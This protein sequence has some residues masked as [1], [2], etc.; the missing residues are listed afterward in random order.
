MSVEDL[1]SEELRSVVGQI[2]TPAP[3]DPRDLIA[4][5]HGLRRRRR[6]VGAVALAATAA[7]VGGI[8]AIGLHPSPSSPSPSR[9]PTELPTGAPPSIGY[10][11]G[12]TLYVGGVPQTGAFSSAQTVGGTTVA[13]PTSGPGRR[14]TVV[15][16]DGRIVDRIRGVD[17]SVLISQDGTKIAYVDDTGT[18]MLLVVHDVGAERDLG[19]LPVSRAL[20]APLNHTP[21][22]GQELWSLADDGTVTYGGQQTSHTWRPG[23]AP[24]DHRPALRPTAPAGLP[25]TAVDAVFGPARTW[26]AWITDRH[27][28]VSPDGG[29]AADGVTVQRPGRP[30]SR[31]VITLPVGNHA[32]AITWETTTDI[33]VWVG[34]DL[35]GHGL[36]YL[37]CNIADQRC[38]YAPTTP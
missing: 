3:P 15:F 8:V 17:G 14:A 2:A 5:S 24:V 22:D 34:T 30:D 38:E 12:S 9:R 10:V 6:A 1:I 25:A 11:D 23:S 13:F 35:N 19:T 29:G 4:R 37:R 21:V 31:R 20:F 7:V 27:G 28:A 18:T 32:F 16:L 26:A 33:L 36:H